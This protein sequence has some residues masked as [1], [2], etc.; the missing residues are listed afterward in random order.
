MALQ[1]LSQ[2]VVVKMM[3]NN[4]L[5]REKQKDGIAPVQSSIVALSDVGDL[6]GVLVGLS[7]RNRRGSHLPK[8]RWL[9]G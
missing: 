9:K 2:H 7:F 3:I 4:S 1:S 6:G 8:S 5:G